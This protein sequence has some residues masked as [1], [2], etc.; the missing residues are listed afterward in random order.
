MSAAGTKN[1]IGT[2]TTMTKVNTDAL[3]TPIRP[4]PYLLGC[5]SI[6]TLGHKLSEQRREFDGWPRFVTR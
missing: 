4:S 3:S 6:S 5:R 1:T 2:S